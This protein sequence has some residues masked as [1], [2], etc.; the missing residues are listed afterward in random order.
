[1]MMMMD[2]DRNCVSKSRAHTR[3][4][5]FLLLSI[6]FSRYFCCA[7]YVYRIR[8]IRRL[9]WLYKSALISADRTVTSLISKRE[10]K[11]HNST[12]KRWKN[13][14]CGKREREKEEKRKKP[15]ISSLKHDGN[16]NHIQCF[17][18]ITFFTASYM[19]DF[20]FLLIWSLFRSAYSNDGQGIFH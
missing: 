11:I 6:S 18:M 15:H 8:L 14:R 3:F 16:T 7:M 4:L 2:Y 13:M 9:A 12:R 1:M 20:F 17:T 19:L 5:F 10:K